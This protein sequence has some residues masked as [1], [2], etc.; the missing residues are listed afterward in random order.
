MVRLRYGGGEGEAAT[1]SRKASRNLC[2][3]RAIVVYRQGISQVL[4]A[5]FAHSSLQK[6]DRPSRSVRA[7]ARAV[8]QGSAWPGEG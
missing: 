3:A 4:V 2:R 1:E 6:N 5:T 8:Y 7:Q